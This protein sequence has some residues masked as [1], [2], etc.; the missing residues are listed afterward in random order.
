MY[1]CGMSMRLRGGRRSISACQSSSDA[2]ALDV[3]KSGGRTNAMGYFVVELTS[4]GNDYG[5]E[6]IAGGIVIIVIV[7]I[8]VVVGLMMI[9]VTRDER[10]NTIDERAEMRKDCV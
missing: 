6:M 7:V 1:D 2:T 3:M 5:R 4:A 9:R 8:V 10:V